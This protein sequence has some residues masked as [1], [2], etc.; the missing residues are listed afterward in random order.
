MCYTLTDDRRMYVSPA[1]ARKIK[2]LDI[3]RNVPFTIC[4]KEKQVGQRK[5]IDWEV[6]RLDQIAER[7]A[8]KA[9]EAAHPSK[10]T[11][12]E[13]VAV[14]FERSCNGNGS[15]NGHG[16]GNGSNGAPVPPIHPALLSSTGK[17]AI[18]IVLEIEAYAHEKAM[19]DFEF[20]A[21]N[22]QKI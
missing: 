12:P 1:V 20:G 5:A 14:P 18:D 7:I 13:P 3:V 4:K 17:A 10:L 9:P 22:I 11:A 6:A 19:T 2:D 8:T 16:N 21:E 15:A